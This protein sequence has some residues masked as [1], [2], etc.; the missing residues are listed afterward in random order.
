V[1]RPRPLGST[2]STK[3]IEPLRRTGEKRKACERFSRSMEEGPLG[4]I[5]SRKN[6]DLQGISGVKVRIFLPSERTPAFV[7]AVEPAGALR[8]TPTRVQLL[9]RVPVVILALL[10]KPS[11]PSRQRSSL[12]PKNPCHRALVTPARLECAR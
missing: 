9:L 5:A 10:A 4:V 3:E 1:Q 8:L 11:P 2:Q 12:H 6:S 7:D